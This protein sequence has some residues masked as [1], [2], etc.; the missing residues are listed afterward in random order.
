MV[1]LSTTR[2]MTVDGKLSAKIKDILIYHSDIKSVKTE[3]MFLQ[4]KIQEYNGCT[5]ENRTFK[6]FTTP[7]FK[8]TYFL[9]P[10]I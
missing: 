4:K 6:K 8:L 2:E 1:L 10:A 7:N 5:D 3:I 9:F